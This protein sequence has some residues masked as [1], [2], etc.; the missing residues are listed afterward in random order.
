MNSS[1]QS[2]D[3]SFPFNTVA[4]PEWRRNFLISEMSAALVTVTI[5]NLF[6]S[7]VTILLN[8]LVIIAVKT[9]PSLRNKYNALL[10]CLAGTDFATG[11]LGQ[12]L[13][14][15]EQIYRLTYSAASD[16]CFIP[17]AA[18]RFSGTFL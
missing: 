14:I 6:V 9:R 7:P 4:I 15:A 1:A 3:C 11:V 2:L 5:F 13:I 16:F 17:Y 18:R 12:P 10:A 8:V